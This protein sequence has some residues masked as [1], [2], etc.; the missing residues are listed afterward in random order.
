MGSQGHRKGGLR[1]QPVPGES[2]R[3]S[4]RLG[5]PGTTR[6]NG[7]LGELTFI[8]HLWVCAVLCALS[9]QSPQPHAAG[10]TIVS[11]MRGTVKDQA[12]SGPGSK[13]QDPTLIGA[14]FP[15]RWCGP[16]F[17]RNQNSAR[18]GVSWEVTW[19]HT[20]THHPRSGVERPSAPASGERG[21][22]ACGRGVWVSKP[23]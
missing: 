6:K 23:C 11:K 3:H 8:D 10:E 15:P 12:G 14:P 16:G 5:P 21:P 4:P 1:P 17:P 20:Y 19:P 9:F 18:T 22:S 2:V 13:V 7:P